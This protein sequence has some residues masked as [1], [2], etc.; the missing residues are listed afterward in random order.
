MSKFKHNHTAVAHCEKIRKVNLVSSDKKHYL[1]D[2]DNAGVSKVIKA[3]VQHSDIKQ[4]KVGGILHICLHDIHSDYLVHIVNY[5][6]YGKFTA[7]NRLQLWPK[8]RMIAT[9]LDIQSIVEYLSE[10]MMMTI[11]N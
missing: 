9:S 4:V 6:N 11:D 2:V 1:V 3:R 7:N 8:L 5:M 10:R